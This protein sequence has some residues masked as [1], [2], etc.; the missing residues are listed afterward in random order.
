MRGLTRQE[1]E[2]AIAVRDAASLTEAQLAVSLFMARK[3]AA[4]MRFS[5]A[6]QQMSEFGPA[7]QIIEPTNNPTRK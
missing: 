3:C 5:V 2:L 1:E 7:T 4:R 6:P